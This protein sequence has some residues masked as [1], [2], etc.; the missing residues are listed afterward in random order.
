MD[1]DTNLFSWEA[2]VPT[3]MYSLIVF[4]YLALGLTEVW[5]EHSGTFV[6]YLT[7]PG[8]QQDCLDKIAKTY[9]SVHAN[10]V[11]RNLVLKLDLFSVAF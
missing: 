10:V 1:I 2:W 11:G 7:H 4:V 5:P 9:S 6:S 3:A 8:S